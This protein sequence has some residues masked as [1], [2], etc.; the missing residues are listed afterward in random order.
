LT[1]RCWQD[2]RHETRSC[3]VRKKTDKDHPSTTRTGLKLSTSAAATLSWD[4]NGCLV[5]DGT[6]LYS[7]DY[8]NRLV[9]VA[10]QDAVPVTTYVYDARQCFALLGTKLCF[11]V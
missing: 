5:D 8:D 2:T 3:A 9:E 11:V 6:Y 10:T 7:Y 1:R 4:D